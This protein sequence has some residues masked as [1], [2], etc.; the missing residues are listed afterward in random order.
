MKTAFISA[1]FAVVLVTPIAAQTADF[2][3]QGAIESGRRVSIGN[4]SGDIRVTTSSSGKVEVLAFKSG[5]S[6][7]FDRIKASAEETPTG[8]VICVV[9]DDPEG[10]C[11]D[12]RDGRDSRGRGPDVSMRLEVAVPTTARVSASNVSGDISVTGA[13]GEIRATTVSGDVMLDKLHS[14][15]ITATSVSG[16]ID[17]RIDELTGN[18]DLEFRSVSG[19]V[20]IQAPKN[21]SADVSMSTVSGDINSDFP[22]TITSGRMKRRNIDARIGAGGRALDVNTVSGSLRIIANR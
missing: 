16:D 19:D 13:H 22:L 21:F 1:A 3:W 17:V 18:G 5:D 20:T 15:G 6:R 10:T 14:D 7:D 8:I 11:S 2:R 4:I 12:H 9:Y